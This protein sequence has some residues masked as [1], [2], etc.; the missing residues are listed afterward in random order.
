MTTYEPDPKSEVFGD[1]GD[2]TEEFSDENKSIVWFLVK[3][4]KNLNLIKCWRRGSNNTLC[5]VTG[6][7]WHGLVK[8][9]ASHFHFRAEVFFG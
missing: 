1:V 3:Q 5:Y 9:C 7:T 4:V 8:G 2:Q 6:S